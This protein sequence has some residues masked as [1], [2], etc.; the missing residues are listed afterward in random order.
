MEWR[1]NMSGITDSIKF[2]A[3]QG[4]IFRGNEE[5]AFYNI[6]SLS[7]NHGNLNFSLAREDWEVQICFNKE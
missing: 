2:I 1:N 5:V 4:L 6:D 7:E 3:K